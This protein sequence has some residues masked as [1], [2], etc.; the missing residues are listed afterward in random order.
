M[1]KNDLLKAIEQLD[2]DMD[3]MVYKL[4]PEEARESQAKVDCMVEIANGIYLVGW[5]AEL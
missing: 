2:N 4:T 3:Y 5:K 1:K